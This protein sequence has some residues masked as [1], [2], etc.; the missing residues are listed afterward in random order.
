MASLLNVLRLAESD[1]CM[2]FDGCQF[3]LVRIDSKHIAPAS[4]NAS[5]PKALSGSDQ[6]G[7][8]STTQGF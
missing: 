2:R 3:R 6:N 7:K 5:G 8:Q 4:S 1:F